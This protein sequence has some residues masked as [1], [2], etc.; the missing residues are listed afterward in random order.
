[1]ESINLS[2]Q[3]ESMIIGQAV[4]MAKRWRY[5]VAIVP[6][7]ANSFH[8][9]WKPD[10]L[11]IKT[12]ALTAGVN[13]NRTGNEMTEIKRT[14]VWNNEQGQLKGGRDEEV[15]LTSQHDQGWDVRLGRGRTGRVPQIYLIS[16]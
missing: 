8:S 6:P 14:P 13:H 3:S 15:D 2:I 10:F 9:V 16:N 7:L 1:M 4:A 11:L 5:K 12:Q